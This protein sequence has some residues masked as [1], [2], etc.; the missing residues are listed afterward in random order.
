MMMQWLDRHVA[1]LM[2]SKPVHYCRMK[3]MDSSNKIGLFLGKL[4]RALKLLMKEEMDQWK[5]FRLNYWCSIII[6]IRCLLVELRKKNKWSISSKN[7]MKKNLL[8]K[9]M[10]KTLAAHNLGVFSS[11]AIFVFSAG[12][13]LINQILKELYLFIW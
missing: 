13:A 5:E 6:D 11:V 10:G 2:N 1:K 9:N 3:K 8:W 12:R 4:M 7:L